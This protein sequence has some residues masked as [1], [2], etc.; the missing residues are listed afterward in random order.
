M[1][2]ATVTAKGQITLPK[3]VREHL[4]VGTG[5]RV[6]FVI[7]EDGRVRVEAVQGDVRR[8]RGRLRRP[9]APSVSLE[10]MQEAIER[11]GTR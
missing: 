3:D 2:V 1:P 7:D 4:R 6:A 10:A 8:L 9:G 5:D 11:G